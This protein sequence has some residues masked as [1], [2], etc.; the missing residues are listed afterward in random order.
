MTT[1]R[2]TARSGIALTLALVL[3][4]VLFSLAFAGWVD[5]GSSILLTMAE[6]GLSWCF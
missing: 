5:H 2:L 3:L 6:T 1:N 4:A